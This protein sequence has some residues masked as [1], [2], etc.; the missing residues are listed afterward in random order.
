MVP[1]DITAYWADGRGYKSLT[2][3]VG[4]SDHE[5]RDRCN[6][7][8]ER[9]REACDRLRVGD[10]PPFLRWHSG[11]DRRVRSRAMDMLSRRASMPLLVHDAP[12]AARFM[13]AGIPAADAYDYAVV[14]CNLNLT[15]PATDTEEIPTPRLHRAT[16]SP[17]ATPAPTPAASGYDWR[18]RPRAVRGIERTP[19]KLSFRGRAALC[20]GDAAP[21]EE[22]T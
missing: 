18:W 2:L 15:L 13:A 10:P 3:T 8:T 16:A 1:D 6:P 22:C 4:G 9:F 11:V 20:Y 12:T 5:G 21:E 17:Q 7:L 14:G 19:G